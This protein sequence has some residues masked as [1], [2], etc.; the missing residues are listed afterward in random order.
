MIA[1]ITND[2]Y[3]KQKQILRSFEKLYDLI[4][5]KRDIINEL[6]GISNSL[7]LDIDS[8]LSLIE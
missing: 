2:S 1:K 8:V 3:Y 5:R 4:E 6:G 7:K